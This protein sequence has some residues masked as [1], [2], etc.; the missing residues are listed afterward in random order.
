[1]LRGAMAVAV[2]RPSCGTALLFNLCVPAALMRGEAPRIS[3]AGITKI[4]GAG[5][6]T[7]RMSR[8]K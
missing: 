4:E 5:G 8:V 1:M 7:T 3:T 2:G 6:E